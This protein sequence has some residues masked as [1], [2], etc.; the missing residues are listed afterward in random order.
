MTLLRDLVLPGTGE[1]PPKTCIIDDCND[2]VR[3]VNT[4]RNYVPR[5]QRKVLKKKRPLVA[6]LKE[7]TS[8]AW[9]KNHLAAGGYYRADETKAL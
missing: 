4:Y 8:P 3:A 6:S 9:L 2:S 1:E 5:K 7:N